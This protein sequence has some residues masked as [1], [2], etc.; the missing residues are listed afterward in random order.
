MTVLAQETATATNGREGKV[1]TPDQQLS[2]HIAPP[3]SD[4]PGTNPEQLFA[5]GYAACFGQAVKAVAGQKGIS[6][7]PSTLAVTAQVNLNKD[8][9]GFYIDA[10]LDVVMPDL[11][12]EQAEAIIQAAHQICPYSKAT[13]GN[14]K[15]ALSAN[16]QALAAAA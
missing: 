12:G 6:L 7:N 16:G 13:R 9:D 8:E 3:G 11:S 1:T 14:I 10:A 5:A 15:V 4:K 2:L